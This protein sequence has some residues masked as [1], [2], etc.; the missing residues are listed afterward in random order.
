MIFVWHSKTWERYHPV[1]QSTFLFQKFIEL[2]YVD[3]EKAHLHFFSE[4][5]NVLFNEYSILRLLQKNTVHLLCIT[6][7][8][9]GIKLQFLHLEAC[10]KLLFCDR[11]RQTCSSHSMTASQERNGTQQIVIKRN[12]NLF[13]R[14]LSFFFLFESCGINDQSIAI[15]CSNMTRD[16]RVDNPFYFSS[17]CWAP[18]TEKV[19]EQSAY[20]YLWCKSQ[21][22][23]HQDNAVSIKSDTFGS[24]YNWLVSSLPAL[25]TQPKSSVTIIKL[26]TKLPWPN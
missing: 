6:V 14:V 23:R 24:Q 4:L 8:Q 25:Q 21:V 1:T 12:I 13:W 15:L 18:P 5:R 16:E 19:I 17:R 26:I 9:F 3:G 20:C 11:A 10:L 2:K 7:W 22:H